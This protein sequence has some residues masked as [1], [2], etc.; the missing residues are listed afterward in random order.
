MVFVLDA[1]DQARLSETWEVFGG[2]SLAELQSMLTHL[3]ALLQPQT[4]ADQSI[5]ESKC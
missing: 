3:K 5:L 4:S 1:C 2:F